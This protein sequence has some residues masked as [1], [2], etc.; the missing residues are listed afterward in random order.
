MN[1]NRKSQPQCEEWFFLSMSEVS[2]SFGVEAEM[3]QDIINEGIISA[4]KDERDQWQFD[5]DAIQRIRIVLH[6]K[7]DLGV[8]IAGAGLALQLMKEIEH[9][10]KAIEGLQKSL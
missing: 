1:D 10:R 2:R 9:L 6:L 4:K 5:A 7:Q 8:N 3:I